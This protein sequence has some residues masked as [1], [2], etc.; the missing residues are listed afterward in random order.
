[1][2]TVPAQGCP[3]RRREPRIAIGEPPERHARAALHGETRAHDPARDLLLTREL[4]LV[5]ARELAHRHVDLGELDEQAERREALERA[6]HLLRARPAAGIDVH[7]EAD[8]V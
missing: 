8:A 5:R 1:M 6:L 7:L 3:L 4:L 2:R